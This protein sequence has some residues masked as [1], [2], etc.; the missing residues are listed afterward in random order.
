MEGIKSRQIFEWAARFTAHSKICPHNQEQK[1]KKVNCQIFESSL[2]PKVLPP[3]GSVEPWRRRRRPTYQFGSMKRRG[4]IQISYPD[5]LSF[6]WTV[7]KNNFGDVTKVIILLRA[8]SESDCVWF[9][10]D[11]QIGLIVSHTYFVV[12][13]VGDGEE[14]LRF[15]SLKKT[16]MRMSVSWIFVNKFCRIWYKNWPLL[17]KVFCL[18]IP[19]LPRHNNLRRIN[20]LQRVEKLQLVQIHLRNSFWKSNLKRIWW[21]NNRR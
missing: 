1:T 9:V 2:H 3:W 20:Q 18:R 15:K 16:K 8:F 7:M 5:C 13:V 21:L 12:A 4:Q 19:P 11:N 10:S 17:M 6:P 14:L